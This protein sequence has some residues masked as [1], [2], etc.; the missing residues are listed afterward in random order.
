MYAGEGKGRTSEWPP[1]LSYLVV[2]LSTARASQLADDFEHGPFDLPS[3][4]HH[5]VVQISASKL[6]RNGSLSSQSPPPQAMASSPS[7]STSGSLQSL[8]RNEH[9]LAHNWATTRTSAGSMSRMK[10]ATV[11][12][13]S[14]TSSK[15]D[16]T[17][18]DKV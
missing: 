10:S 15:F 4:G 11:E 8:T 9:L 2:G 16:T 1:E 7:P 18:S 12:P 3:G 13:A 17:L 6:E 5:V 14:V